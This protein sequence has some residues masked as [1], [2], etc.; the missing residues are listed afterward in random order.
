MDLALN[1]LQ[2]LICH[3]TQSIRP[4]VRCLIVVGLLDLHACGQSDVTSAKRRGCLVIYGLV[5]SFN[6]E[7]RKVNVSDAWFRVPPLSLYL[8]VRV[9]VLVSGCRPPSF[10]LAPLSR[11]L[12]FIAFFVFRSDQIGFSLLFFLP[13]KSRT[14]RKI[15]FNDFY[16]LTNFIDISLCADPM[17]RNPFF[18]FEESL[19]TDNIR[20]M[21]SWTLVGIIILCVRWIRRD[22][23][24]LYIKIKINYNPLI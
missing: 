10:D 15:I 6:A 21:L 2:R 18:L 20:W 3:K 9:G 17:R 12:S 19:S 23:F 8:S 16:F 1:N 5:A 24:R 11:N 22:L 4:N 7:K 14:D 13:R